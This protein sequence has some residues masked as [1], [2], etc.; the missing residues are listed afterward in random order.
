M[1]YVSKVEKPSAEI[2][3]SLLKLVRF[4]GNKLTEI[5]AA[6]KFY[7]A[8]PPPDKSFDFK[9][10]KEEVVCIEL[11]RL[12][13][14]KCAYCESNYSAVDSRDIEHFRPKGGGK[15]VALHMG[16]WWLA[17]EWNNL[18]ISCPACNQ[19]R[20]QTV[21]RLGMTRE[22][23]EAER[24]KSPL[25]GRGKG[26][27]FPLTDETKRAIK[28]SD[29]LNLEDP[30]L[31]N[32]TLKNPS[33][34]LEWIFDWNKAETIWE[35]ETLI[36]HVVPKAVNG[37]PDPYGVASITIYGLDRLDLFKARVV[38]L[39]LVQDAVSTLFE[40]LQDMSEA[41]S[42]E[43]LLVLQARL[44]KKKARLKQLCSR[45]EVYTAMSRAFVR[46]ALAE[47]ARLAA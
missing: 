13:H 5:D 42:D 36:T 34:H 43:K 46:L 38:Q 4:E 21:Y 22:E 6:R 31:I 3:N 12:F 1:I 14:G 17:A 25:D 9:R 7:S 18:L 26:C 45:K 39:R 32:P 11:D 23:I 8:V 35:S 30:L 44:K 40:T 20:M 24:K 27:E 33:K 37:V 2:L 29:I 28:E 19:Y 15:G 47:L 41:I 16:Y 10:Y